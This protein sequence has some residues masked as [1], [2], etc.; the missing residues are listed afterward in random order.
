MKKL[1]LII[2]SLGFVSSVFATHNRAGEI[3]YRKVPG[4]ER[5][6]DVTITTYT[7]D[8]APADRC[9]LEI[10][11]GDGTSDI[12]SRTNG[13]AILG[14]AN[15]GVDVGNDIRLN[16]YQGRHTYAVFGT[17]TLSF[18]DPNRNDNVSNIDNSVNIPFYVES[19]LIINPFLG[20]NSSPSLLNPPI[21][22]G[23]VN[24]IFL[25]NPSAF[26]ID[27][28]SLSYKLVNSKAANGIDIPE[29][30][31]PN[32]APGVDLIKIDSVTG[33][34]KWDTPLLAG[35]YNMAIEISEWRKDTTTNKFI[36]IGK[37]VRDM[38]VDILNCNN[39][40]PEIEEVGEICVEAGD[41]INLPIDA[42]DINND[43]IIFTASGGPFTLNP[44]AT[45]ISL[46]GGPGFNNGL[47]TWQTD[48][49]HVRKQPYFVNF[50]AVDNGNPSLVDFYTLKIQVIAPGPLN[51]M[52]VPTADSISLNWNSSICT[53][54][55]AYKIYRKPDSIAFVNDSCV[56]GVPES[57]G[58]ELIHT[59]RGGLL[60]TAYVDNDD[61][62]RG[63]RYCY[64][65]VACF[66]D[67]A[68]SYASVETCAELS[69]NVPIITNVDVLN[70]DDVNGQIEIRWVRPLVIDTPQAPGPYSYEIFR[71]TGTNGGTFTSIG[72]TPTL[73]DTLF[74]D[75]TIDTRTTGYTYRIDI[76]NNTPG[77]TF[78]LGSSTAASSIFLTAIP[79]D[80]QNR[81]NFN[82]T[83]P[84]INDTIV[85]FREEPPAS[86]NF[87]VHDTT[88]DPL[89]YV[90]TN[91]VN[92]V[93]RC[94][95][96]EAIGRYSGSGLPVP[97][98]NTS[99][100]VCSTPRDTTAPC[101]LDVVLNLDC[102]ESQL[103]LSWSGQNCSQDIQ[104]YNVYFNADPNL[105]LQVV[106]TITDTFFNA[107]N[108]ASIAGCYAVTAVDS[109]GNESGFSNIHCVS[110]CPSLE[111][112]NV[113]TP[114]G[115][116]NN[117][118]FIP[119]NVNDLADI[120]II[121][122]NRWG[123]IVYENTDL[124]NFIE[125]GWDGTHKDNGQ[126]CSQGVYFYIATGRSVDLGNPES[127]TFEGF[128]H[129][130]R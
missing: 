82:Y 89:T 51:P 20:D 38:Q 5:T 3:T 109:V 87:V 45:F 123:N 60:D 35:Q 40:P 78:V 47:F 104:E 25:H 6:Y 107:S 66:P 110:A 19:I 103:V 105:P 23:C 120:E 84:W 76:H 69:K 42:T 102:E 56:P 128:I 26:D 11:W 75:N 30:Y 15:G 99:Q 70:T 41:F 59:N 33:E 62:A 24:R 111:L 126:L 50:K 112:P 108:F 12:I 46:G 68:E 36:L 65:I 31:D 113:F 97:L 93:E 4:Q 64:M 73:T 14:C 49:S 74:T 37:V 88:T 72:T 39:D 96:V 67:G 79:S 119:V 124:D 28:D 122:Y 55:I 1:L 22:I 71:A 80:N 13:P 27:G 32:F 16:I 54:A 94:Y 77:N 95:L 101:P 63:V 125:S 43:N 83:V 8:S 130:Y 18:E 115:D 85:I 29:V 2:F 9:D 61:L 106:A 92:G 90:D 57:T 98:L 21:D 48:C 117:D 58:Y 53:D 121:I 86:G 100:E 17:Y 114:N 116:G 7:K 91:L 44:Q 129:L 81:L 10:D 52:A 127:I 118:R 34:L